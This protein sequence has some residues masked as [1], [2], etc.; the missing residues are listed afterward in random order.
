MG[1]TSWAFHKYLERWAGNYR[2]IPVEEVCLLILL[3]GKAVF[4]PAPDL[5]CVGLC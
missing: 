3:P 5:A 1:F 2:S 4:V